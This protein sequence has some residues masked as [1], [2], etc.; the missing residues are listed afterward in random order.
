MELEKIIIIPDVHGRIFWE[1][2]VNKYKNVVGVHIVFLGDYLDAYK[3]IDGIEAEDAIANFEKIIET[4]RSSNNITL[5]LGNHDLHYWDEFL[6]YRGCRRYE[7]YKQDINNM[8]MKN[9]DLFSI[10]YE[11]YINNKQYLFTHAGVLVKW[12]DWVTGKLNR[13]TIDKPYY[14][15]DFIEYFTKH[16]DG[17]LEKFIADNESIDLLNIELNANGLNSLLNSCIGRFILSMVGRDRG[18][19]DYISSC[20]WCDVSEHYWANSRF[21]ANNLY[22]IFSHSFGFPSLNEY[23]IND[24]WAMLDCRKAFELDCKTGTIKEYTN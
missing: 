23:I 1:E 8:F 14:F 12:F 18:G 20:L 7:L 21:D 6:P 15:K 3:D 2:P 11:T 16:P 4:A 9:I 19:Y 22:Q 24:E 10:A 17:P 13:G 5:L